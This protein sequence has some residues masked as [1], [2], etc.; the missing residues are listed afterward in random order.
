MPPTSGIDHDYHDLEEA[1]DYVTR[2]KPARKPKA[3]KESTGLV[4]G[5]V[6]RGRGHHYD[7]QVSGDSRAQ[8]LLCEVRGRLLQERAKDTLVAVGDRVWVQ[9]AAGNK[10]LI[11]RIDERLSVL[12][13]QQPGINIPA[14][15]VI[16][17]NPDQALVVFAAAQPEPHLRMLDRFLVIAE[18]NELPAVLCVNKVELVGLEACAASFGLYER[19]GYPVLYASAARPRR[20]RRTARPAD[21]PHHGSH[22][23]QRRR[24]EQPA[25]RRSSAISNLRTGDLRDFARQ[26]PHT[27]RAPRSSY[28]AALWRRHLC[29][30][31]ARH[32]RTGA[33][34]YRTRKTLVLF[35]RDAA[36]SARL[37]LSRLHARS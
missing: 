24:Q 3:K 16:L 29:G 35:P 27:R 33:L 25:Q 21:R 23:A 2:E 10:G 19:I 9:P 22:R 31:H 20:H 6:V 32:P 30:R 1:F 11:E 5:V 4:H 8:P 15:D 28:P 13:R 14:E 17:A 34:R 37:P 7:V 12:S 18:A 26:G 36:F